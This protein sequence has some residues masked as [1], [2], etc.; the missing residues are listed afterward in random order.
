MILNVLGK[1]NKR[2]IHINEKLKDC[3]NMNTFR[4]YGE[5]ITANLYK[6]D[7]NSKLDLISV[8]NYYD[9]QNIIDIPLDKRF[10]LVK[11]QKDILKV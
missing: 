1:Y 7:N 4:I 11:M 5:L 8:E 2:L 10:L 3:D 6:F 9:N